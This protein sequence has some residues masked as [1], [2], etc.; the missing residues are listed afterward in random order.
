M[1]P[2]SRL[3]ERTIEDISEI[4]TFRASNKMAARNDGMRKAARYRCPEIGCTELMRCIGDKF[5]SAYE[6]PV[7][8]E[9]FAY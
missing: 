2:D 3:T 8:L 4:V 7:Y 9:S 5:Q 1:I 6:E